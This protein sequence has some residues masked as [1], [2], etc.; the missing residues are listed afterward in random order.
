MRGSACEPDRV[1]KGDRPLRRLTVQNVLRAR[2]RTEEQTESGR[3][4]RHLSE[5][6]ELA[7][8]AWTA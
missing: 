4:E 7:P 1:S 6:L 8:V 2:D 3:Q 5:V